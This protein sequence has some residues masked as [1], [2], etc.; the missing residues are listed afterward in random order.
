MSTTDDIKQLIKD[1]VTSKLKGCSIKVITTNKS[2]KINI[3]SKDVPGTRD[4]CIQILDVFSESVKYVKN[5]QPSLHSYESNSTPISQLDIIIAD[6]ATQCR[7]IF[8]PVSNAT[9]NTALLESAQCLFCAIYQHTGKPV[10]LDQLPLHKGLLDRTCQTNASIKDMLSAIDSGWFDSLTNVTKH[11]FK[12]ILKNTTADMVFHRDSDFVKLVTGDLFKQMNI[13]EKKAGEDV[14]FSR[15]D[16]WNPADIW[17]VNQNQEDTITKYL[18]QLL[19]GDIVYKGKTYVS[20]YKGYNDFMN[21]LIIDGLLFP[22]SLKKVSRGGSVHKKNM[23]TPSHI[24]CVR[25]IDYSDVIKKSIGNTGITI[26]GIFKDNEVLNFRSFTSSSFSG[27]LI[28][29]EA[30]GGKVGLETINYYLKKFGSRHTLGKYN[31]SNKIDPE[32]LKKKISLL[33]SKDVLKHIDEK[34]LFKTSDIAS[35]SHCIDLLILIK[36]LGSKSKPFMTSL[37][38]YAGAVGDLNGPYFLI[39]S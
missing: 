21:Q 36:D 20:R 12:N 18:K 35:Y 37:A 14:S 1:H 17:I 4:K 6:K 38:K 33:V 19:K 9:V 25:D 16:K 3:M 24:E 13:N 7:F 32:M 23:G 10:T 26:K 8:K 30:R 31:K 28:G 34:K 5:Y 39:S 15:K 11:V 29:T 2:I 27:E 22:V